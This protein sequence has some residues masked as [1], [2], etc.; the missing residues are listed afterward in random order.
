MS[1]SGLRESEEKKKLAFTLETIERNDDFRIDSLFFIQLANNAIANI[2]HD[3]FSRRRS[4]NATKKGHRHRQS[5]KL[6]KAIT[7]YLSQ[8]QNGKESPKDI[9]RRIMVDNDILQD[10]TFRIFSLL[11]QESKNAL[12]ES[13]NGNYFNN[14]KDWQTFCND[15][16]CLRRKRNSLIHY[17]PNELFDDNENFIKAMTKLLLAHLSEEFKGMVKSYLKKQKTPNID[18]VLEPLKTIIS[19]INASK[20]RFK[21]HKQSQKL[22]PKKSAAERRRLEKIKQDL[23]EKRNRYYQDKDLKS[24]L[25]NFKNLYMF[26]GR[27]HIR[28]IKSVFGGIDKNKLHLGD[29]KDIFF[30]STRI[31]LIINRQIEKLRT[32]FIAETKVQSDKFKNL[33]ESLPKY[34]ADDKSKFF[35]SNLVNIRNAIEHNSPAYNCSKAK[36]DYIKTMSGSD[37]QNYFNQIFGDGTITQAADKYSFFEVIC[38][39]MKAIRDYL[40]KQELN[41]FYTQ[42]IMTI[43]QEKYNFVKGQGKIHSWKNENGQKY[44]KD[45]INYRRV[46]KKAAGQWHKDICQAI[47]L[48]KK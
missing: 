48:L 24:H 37:Y 22:K 8:N 14:Y 27:K 18:T 31:N 40:G 4:K 39:M 23:I 12:V 25:L 30:L 9:Y 26:I 3:Y 5:R 2:V 33:I 17:N 6:Y 11:P 34:S 36:N 42:L 15:W 44:D 16:R 19:E 38:F 35:L 10:R 13:I 45:K 7:G 47:N 43:E 41:N 21:L 28:N 29:Y 1:E 46:V 20:K 32:V